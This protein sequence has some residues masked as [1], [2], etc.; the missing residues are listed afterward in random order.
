MDTVRRVVSR[1][2]WEY[3]WNMFAIFLQYFCNSFAIF[4]SPYVELHRGLCSGV[5]LVHLWVTGCYVIDIYWYLYL[6]LKIYIIPPSHP[7][8][9]VCDFWHC[10][11]V[12]VSNCPIFT[13]MYHKA[14]KIDCLPNKFWLIFNGFNDI[15]IYTWF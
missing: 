8:W 4:C 1:I 10:E 7:F 14:W 15:Y 3:F 13:R 11:F 12:W 6:V 5:T 9:V 2:F